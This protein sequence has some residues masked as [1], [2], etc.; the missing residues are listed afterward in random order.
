[1]NLCSKKKLLKQCFFEFF[2]TGLIVF[3]GFI[4]LGASKLTNFHFNHY[5]MSFI[6]GL[7]V[8]ISIYFNFSISGAHLNPAITI[9]LWLSSQFNKKKV[10][11]YLISQIFGTFF[12]S[13][14]VYIIYYKLL[15]TFENK[16]NIIRG[17]K[18]SLEL[19]SIFC[20]FP[21]ENNNFIYDFILEIII[22]SLFIVLLMKINEKNNFF[23]SYNFMRPI[24]IG[25][26]VTLLN[27]SL[28]DCNNITLNPARDLG[29]RI[30]LSLFGWGKLVFINDHKNILPY[31]LIPEIAPILGINL[32]GWI[33]IIILKR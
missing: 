21:K 6:W 30:F 2:G 23:Q 22:S 29:P 13:I 1:M 15:I 9:F 32:G 3:I 10:I 31:F 25:I 14:I 26:L 4:F 5:E 27:L 7:G 16:Y 12:F 18:K 11:P 28:G 8:S 24:L 20:I 33:Y 17:T 19:A